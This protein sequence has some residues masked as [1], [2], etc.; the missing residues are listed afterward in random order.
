MRSRFAGM[1]FLRIFFV[2]FF[3]FLF[4]ENAVFLLFLEKG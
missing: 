4:F 1:G 3:D 2:A